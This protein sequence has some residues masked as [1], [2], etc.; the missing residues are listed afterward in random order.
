VRRGR[1]GLVLFLVAGAF[2]VQTI[3]VPFSMFP[4]AG[5][6]VSPD[7]R[8]EVRDADRE[9]SAGE[10]VG[11]FHSLWLIEMATRSSRKLCDYVGLAAVAW[12]SNDYLVVTQYV[13]KKTSRALVFAAAASE[14]PVLLDTS[15]L[16]QMVPVELRDTLR[17][18]DH[19]FVEASRLVEE[20]F[21]FHVWGYGKHDPSG[22]RWNCEYSLREDKVLCPAGS[23][24]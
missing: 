15:T 6:L 14:E 7:G 8:Y 10:F 11:T 21:Y 24:K 5:H 16:I 13:G 20:T 2:C 1:I 3:A 23:K 18:N 17:G 4:K 19:V 12:S 9:G 22:F